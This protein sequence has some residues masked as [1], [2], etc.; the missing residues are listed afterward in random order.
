MKTLHIAPGDSAGGSL[1]MAIRNA[2]R[3]DEVL[4]F[5]DDLSCGPIASD[6]PAPR[7]S[8][9][10]AFYDS[11]EVEA[12]LRSFWDQATS[13]EGRLIVWFGRHSASELAFFLAW[14]DR[15]TGRPYDI[16]DVTARQVP[17]RQQDGS[18]VSRPA[19]FVSIVR[20]EALQLLLGSERP[21]TAKERETSS[22]HWRRLRN[23]NAPFR[24]VTDAGLASAPIDYFD[25]W[26][27]Q[28]AT[29]EWRTVARVVG[30]VMGHNFEP[31]DQVHELMLLARVTALVDQG[32]LLAEGDP[33]D[34]RSRVR[35][36]A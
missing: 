4:R 13:F 11:S 33:W 32:K 31:Y 9:W 6:D 23:E 26:I 36:P 15:V 3:D 17:F 10:E 22:R 34:M 19:Q 12:R 18:F 14:T 25:P 28:Q 8:W 1:L 30:E 2:G 35:L 7:A 16:I 5:G 24:I 27:L 21:I 20:H 29:T